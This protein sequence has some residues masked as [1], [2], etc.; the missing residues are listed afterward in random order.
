MPLLQWGLLK[1]QG[2]NR[3]Y[4][5]GVVRIAIVI[6]VVMVVLVVGRRPERRYEF[7]G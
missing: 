6:R 3:Q 5:C 7:E 1:K 4:G 2:S